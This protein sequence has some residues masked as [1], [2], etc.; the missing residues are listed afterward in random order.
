MTAR[1]KIVVLMLVWLGGLAGCQGEML[2]TEPDGAY[3]LFR[4]AVLSGD[5]KTAY[6]FLDH[7]T[8]ALFDERVVA[9]NDMQDR[10][11]RFLPQVD[12][13]LARQ[14]TGVVL[15]KKNKLDSG[16]ALFLMLFTPDKLEVTPEIEVGSEISD[17]EVSEDGKEA[18]LVTYSGQQYRLVLEGTEWRVSSWAALAAKRTQWILDNRTALEQTVQDLIAE[19]KEEV[20]RVIAF[21]IA[22]DKARKAAEKDGK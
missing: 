4:Q 15:L 5:S 14:Q 13:R 21:L 8:K 20:D 19:E 9:L 6:E 11:D 1:G 16:N 10:I 18:I 7:D 22:E 12:Q 3:L 2:P 17:L